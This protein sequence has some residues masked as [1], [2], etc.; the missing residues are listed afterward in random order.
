MKS[1]KWWVLFF[2]FFWLLCKKGDK[3]ESQ[4]GMVNL[5]KLHFQ[6][7]SL[8]FSTTKRK[9]YRVQRLPLKKGYGKMRKKTTVP[10]VEQSYQRNHGGTN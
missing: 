4:K 1:T 5:R 3:Q 10:C 9:M 8:Q 7:Q 6:L 2:F